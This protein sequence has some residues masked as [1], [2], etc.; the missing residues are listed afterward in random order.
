MPWNSLKYIFQARR[1]LL[2]PAVHEEFTRLKVCY[3]TWCW[4]LLNR[5]WLILL[6]LF[7]RR[8]TGRW[9]KLSVIIRNSCWKRKR[10]VSSSCLQ[11]FSLTDVVQKHFVTVW[12]VLSHLI[13][14]SCLVHW[15]NS[16][17]FLYFG[18]N[19]MKWNRI[20]TEDGRVCN[21]CTLGRQSLYSWEVQGITFM[22]EGGCKSVALWLVERNGMEKEI[23]LVF[24]FRDEGRRNGGTHFFFYFLNI[25]MYLSLPL[26]FHQINKIA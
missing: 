14:V 23:I 17:M 25:S 16:N 22:V 1:L 7:C 13:P 19:K 6:T 5:V 12:T 2:D 4:L 15:G 20:T 8:N 9:E 18:G 26:I 3:L 24:W 10:L 11:T 21:L